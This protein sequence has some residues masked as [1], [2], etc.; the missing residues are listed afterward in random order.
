MKIIDPSH[1]LMYPIANPLKHIEEIGRTCYKSEDAITEI[2]AEPFVQ[3]LFNRGHHAMIEHFRFIVELEMYD[4]T[5]IARHIDHNKYITL[6]EDYRDDGEFH[7]VMSASARGINDMYNAIKR[8]N[9]ANS[10]ADRMITMTIIEDIVAVIVRH[11]KCA[12]MFDEEMVEAYQS[13]YS[14]DREYDARVITT[15]GELSDYEYQMHAW[16]SIM[17]TCDRGV[18]HEMVRH[19][20]ASFAQESTRYC[21]YSQGKHGEEITVIR[22]PFWKEGSKGWNLWEASCKLS[23][24]GYL[25]L[26]GAGASPQEARA[27][28]PHSTKAEIVITAQVYEWNHIFDLRVLGKTGAPHPQIKQVMEPAFNEMMEKNLL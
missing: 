6:T 26:I 16:Y 21:N 11:Y 5:P 24:A 9:E 15:F 14:D 20:D 25:F 10:S 19:R 22:P 23:E 12:V 28:L 13:R 3:R 1:R 27:V 18:T 2:S 17:F 8:D 7:Y 4:Y